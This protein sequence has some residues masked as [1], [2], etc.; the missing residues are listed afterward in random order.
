S[1]SFL[2]PSSWSRSRCSVCA[3]PRYLLVLRGVPGVVR[4][5]AQRCA[6]C[7]LS[8]ANRLLAVHHGPWNCVACGDGGTGLEDQ[9]HDLVERWMV[10]PAR[11]GQ[12]ADISLVHAAD[13]SL[14]VRLAGDWQLR[15]QLPSTA[16]VER[17]IA[18]RPPQVTFEADGLGRWDSSLVT[19][20]TRIL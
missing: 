1:R 10:A 20:L 7:S 3:W 11:G 18:A 15:G 14:L 8:T 2:R 5:P 6:S 13:G 4:P 12:T 17:E 19:S 9:R 16:G